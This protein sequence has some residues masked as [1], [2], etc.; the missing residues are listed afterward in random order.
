MYVII[1]PHSHTLIGQFVSAQLKVI[2]GGCNCIGGEVVLQCTTSGTGFTMYNVTGC[3]FGSLNLPHTGVNGQP[4][5][6]EC[7]STTGAH[8]VAEAQNVTNGG[9]FVSVL[10]ITAFP[11]ASITVECYHEVA[12]NRNWNQNRIPI[13]SI[14]LKTGI[15]FYNVH[16]HV[17]LIANSK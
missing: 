15:T 4:A 17:M 6:Q 11:N 14:T 3:Q 16:V 13:G 12:Q 2:S 9:T 8:I 7:S 1:V 5:V 10:N